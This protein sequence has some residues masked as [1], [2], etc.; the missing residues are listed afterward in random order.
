[1][2]FLFDDD[3]E[4]GGPGE[5]KRCARISSRLTQTDMGRAV[6]V[7]PSS[8]FSFAACVDYFSLSLSLSFSFGTRDM[9]VTRLIDSAVDLGSAGFPRR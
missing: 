6:L 7:S 3:R 5:K 9:R 4:S 8:T 1:M 2:K